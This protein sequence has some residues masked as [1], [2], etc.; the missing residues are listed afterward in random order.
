M[1]PDGLSGIRLN[2][3]K[4]HLGRG[5]GEVY[6][7]F[8]VVRLRP[9]LAH[10]IRGELRIEALSVEGGE[11]WFERAR[12]KQE[13]KR[14]TSQ[15]SLRAQ[16]DALARHLA[17]GASFSGQDLRMN[18]RGLPGFEPITGVT[19]LTLEATLDPQGGF[20]LVQEATGHGVLPDGLAFVVTLGSVAPSATDEIAPAHARQISFE[21][22]GFQPGDYLA[23][24]L[25]LTARLDRVTAC[26]GC[27]VYI[28][29]VEQLALHLERTPVDVSILAPDLRLELT[30]TGML[31]T[32]SG[33]KLVLGSTTRRLID[34]EHASLEL[35]KTGSAVG[36]ARL[37]DVAGG[38]LEL[39]GRWDFA[40]QRGS[41]DVLIKEFALHNAHGIVSA[42][43]PLHRA[44]ADGHVHSALDLRLGLVTTEIRAQ[45][46]DTTVHLPFLATGNLSFERVALTMDMLVDINGRSLSIT[47]GK[48]G[49][50]HA[51]P[52]D[53][54][55][56]VVD[57][58]PGWSFVAAMRG[59]GL[60]APLLLDSLPAALTGVL[61]DARMQGDFEFSLDTAGHTAYPDSLVLDARFGGDVEVL[62]DG[63]Y[64]DVRVLKGE[65]AP[66]PDVSGHGVRIVGPGAWTSYDALP[67]HVPQALLAAE[68]ASFLKHAGLDWVGLRMA[69]VH[70]LR[71]GSFERGGSTISQQLAKNLFLTHDRTLS[72]KLQEAFLT[73]RIESELDKERILE[74]Y[75]N[76]VE[77][78]PQ[79]H[80]I[81]Y[82]AEYYFALNPSELD[83]AQMV[84]LA[85]ILPNPVRF[86]SALK[87]GFIPSSRLGKAQRALAN[88]RFLGHLSWEDYYRQNAALSRAKV[89]RQQFSICADD[90]SAPEGAPSCK[91]A[92]ALEPAVESTIPIEAGWIPL[93]R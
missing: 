19:L 71:Q 54:W 11:V 87:A 24:D 53:F 47:G 81:H 44:L 39:E 59:E 73:W 86:G 16:L 72:R 40:T 43:S 89:G 8:D 2:G 61:R 27:S 41:L 13:T 3:V 42:R 50:G 14:S 70:N 45:L 37:Q 77:W 5:I 66:S 23:A 60:H 90:E 64:I 78:G 22:P 12:S 65:G 58:T 31:C 25:P 88:M 68:D 17:P 32:T 15:R 7:H 79:I 74:I 93:T 84:L 85:A 49:V 63:R 10:L 6:A 82:A 46:R 38:H 75:L 48:L 67:P 62:R 83:V 35:H 30:E 80:G 20:P 36:R 76:V 4:V 34:V 18:A 26:I 57:T 28:I 52:I 92:T 51:T 55:G 33:S 91:E 9:S 29:D 69:M 56:Q 1:A 21:A